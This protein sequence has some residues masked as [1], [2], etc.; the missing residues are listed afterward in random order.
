MRM[1]DSRVEF[2]PGS[3]PTSA[4][5]RPAGHSGPPGTDETGG[6]EDVLEHALEPAQVRVGARAWCGANPSLGP[7]RDR[8]G[9]NANGLG[10]VERGLPGVG[11]NAGEGLAAGELVPAE[12]VALVSEHE[13][14]P[15]RPPGGVGEGLWVQWWRTEPAASGRSH[16]PA[17]VGDRRLQ[18]GG[19]PH[20]GEHVPGADGERARPG[21]VRA[22]GWTHPGPIGLAEVL[23]R[24]GGGAEVLGRAGMDEDEAD[25][26]GHRDRRG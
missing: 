5:D 18:G 20:G 11:G 9:V 1:A 8:V 26:R 13:G 14:H 19:E 25:G 15:P 6:T 17:A 24:P 21:I 23:E 12:P 10:E 3:N 2:Q 7:A 22:S 4:M 16:D